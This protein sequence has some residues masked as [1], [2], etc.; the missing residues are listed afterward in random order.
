MAAKINFPVVK[1]QTTTNPTTKHH[2]AA[3]ALNVEEGNDNV[4]F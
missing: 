3:F 1:N 2:Q 4:S